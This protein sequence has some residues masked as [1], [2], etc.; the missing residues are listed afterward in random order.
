MA[1]NVSV[2]YNRGF[3][4]DIILLSRDQILRRERGKGKIHFPVQL[5]TSRIGNLTRLILTLAICD[6]HTCIIHTSDPM[7]L[8]SGNT[9][10]YHEEVLS[11]QPMI[12]P[13]RFDIFP[14][15]GGCSEG[16]DAFRF[17]F[18]YLP[19]GK[20]TTYSP[21]KKETA[22]V[23]IL[24]KR[25][26]PK[27]GKNLSSATKLLNFTYSRLHAFFSF[28]YYFI[29]YYGTKHKI[30]HPFKFRTHETRAIYSELRGSPLGLNR[31]M[32]IV[33]YYAILSSIRGKEHD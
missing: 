20:R 22:E 19:E 8:P 26:T 5:T 7:L 28:R 18:K 33:L 29:Q 32:N 30:N 31:Y 17:F 27:G 21:Y 25:H 12:P 15:P 11:L 6:D 4:P 13:K 1:I 2:Q 24:K 16:L 10:N 3:L 14:L 23:H 9:N